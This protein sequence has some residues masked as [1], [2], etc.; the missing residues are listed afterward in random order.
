MWRACQQLVYCSNPGL[1]VRYTNTSS[2]M[3]YVLRRTAMQVGVYCGLRGNQHQHACSLHGLIR[4]AV[5]GPNGGPLQN[6]G[7]SLCNR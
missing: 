4:Q 7:S 5:R 3:L 2:C 6:V 1:S